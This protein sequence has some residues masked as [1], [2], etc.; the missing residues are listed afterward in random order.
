MFQDWTTSKVASNHCFLERFTG[1][2]SVLRMLWLQRQSCICTPWSASPGG[3]GSQACE[4]VEVSQQIIWMNFE[5]QSFA[6]LEFW[7]RSLRSL[8][9]CEDTSV[10]KKSEVLKLLHWALGTLHWLQGLVL[11]GLSFIRSLAELKAHLLPSSKLQARSLG[12]YP[13]GA[14]SARPWIWVSFAPWWHLVIY[15]HLPICNR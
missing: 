7:C 14:S 3:P 13:W 8:W 1:W 12:L 6:H 15:S 11:V 10:Y 2:F 9:G 5:V 4:V